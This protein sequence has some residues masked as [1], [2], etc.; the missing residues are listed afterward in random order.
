LDLVEEFRQ[1]V[2]DRTVI[3]FINLGQQIG[4]E[5]GLLDPGDTESDCRENSR[6]AEQRRTLPRPAVS[7]PVNRPNAGAI[8]GELPSQ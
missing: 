7:D 6:K 8:F 4:M 5:N 1:P 2:V 3:A